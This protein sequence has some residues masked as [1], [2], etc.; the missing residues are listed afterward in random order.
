MILSNCFT[1]RIS[2]LSLLLLFDLG[3]ILSFS[4]KVNSEQMEHTTNVNRAIYKDCKSLQKH[5]NTVMKENDKSIE[6]RG[7]EKLKMYRHAP[8]EEYLQP[9]LPYCFGGY[10]I[11]NSPKGTYVCLGSIVETRKQGYPISYLEWRWGE[12]DVYGDRES[13]YCRWRN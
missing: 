8:R 9:G 2:R 10:I 4:P 6:F 1:Q 3:I 13:K 11:S 5:F 12:Y 7:F